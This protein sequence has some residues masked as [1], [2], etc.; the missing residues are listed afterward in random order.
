MEVNMYLSKILVS[1]PACHNPY[2]IHRALWKLF[3]EDTGANR[4]F[5]FHVGQSDQNRAEILMQSNR[6][7]IKLSGTAKILACKE[8]NPTLSAGYRLR[9]LLI[10]NPVKM[11]NDE[12]ERKNAKG[13]I[14][15]CRVPLIREDDQ[16]AWIERK[17]GAAASLETLIIDPA[18]S[19]KFRKTREDQV[20][21]IQP[22]SFQGILIVEN[23][24]AMTALLKTGIGPAKAF[25]CGLMLVRRI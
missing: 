5:L 1:G 24:E 15:K 19:I 25:G 4:D 21:K 10:A 18:I 6:E 2:E 8:Y 13:D 23:A 16:R 22:V 20:G 11:I 7:P 14:K 9:F 3:P 12:G 17:L